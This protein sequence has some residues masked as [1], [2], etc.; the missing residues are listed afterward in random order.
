MFESGFNTSFNKHNKLFTPKFEYCSSWLDVSIAI[1]KIL[2]LFLK[3]ASYWV[4]VTE[5]AWSL[6]KKLS[7]FVVKELN[8]SLDKNEIW[9]PLKSIICCELKFFISAFVNFT[10]ASTSV[11]KISQ[12]NFPTYDAES[13]AAPPKKNPVQLTI[14]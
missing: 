9:I 10:I 7:W 4:A 6:L 12:I 5:L 11:F 1:S 8:W 14:P 2:I 13:Q 3:I